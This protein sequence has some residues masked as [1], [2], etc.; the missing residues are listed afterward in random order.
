LRISIVALLFAVTACSGK[1]DAPDRRIVEVVGSEYAF[2]A[3]RVLPAGPVVFQFVNR[4][5]VRHELNVF[6][7]KSGTTLEQYLALRKQKKPTQDLIDGPVGVLFAEPGRRSEAG[8]ATD[9]IAGREYVAICVFKDN[10]TGPAH[11]DLGMYSSIRVQGPAVAQKAESRRDAVIGRDYTFTYPATLSPGRH[12]LAFE[13]QGKVPHEMI[14]IRLKQGITTDS[15]LK[16][17]KTNGDTEVL[18][19]DAPG[20]LTAQPGKS[21]A[22]RLEVDLLPGREY[23]L[24]CFFSDS[25]N[26]P[27]HVALGMYGRIL[28]TG[29]PRN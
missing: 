17:A 5:K 25:T 27:P 9:L 23:T 16:V 4:G 8:L 7:L 20:L 3:P 19:D 21:S 11:Y 13:N 6:M 26:A 12:A 10:P 28:V 22:G 29:S 14:L 15:L 1:Q 24:A 2:Q 18:I